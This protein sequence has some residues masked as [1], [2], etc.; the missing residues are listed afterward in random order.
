MNRRSFLV[1]AAAL[2]TVPACSALDSSDSGDAE[3]TEG[4]GTLRLGVLPVIDYTPVYIARDEGLF[5]A[6]GLEVTVES[7][8]GGA[9]LNGI[10]SGDIDVAAATHVLTLNGLNNEAPFRFAW[11][12]YQA[13]AN[14]LVM[15][16]A[17]NSPVQRPQDLP[18]RRVATAVLANVAEL[19]TSIVANQ[20]GVDP[21]SIEWVEIP[22][23]AMGAALETGQVDAIHVVEPFITL[24]G[25]QLGA[26]ILLD[27]AS[28]ATADY[29]LGGYIVTTQFAEENRD[30]VAAFQRAMRRA[31]EMA[32][33]DR[34]LVERTLPTF[35]ELDAET[36]TLLN[37]GVFP[38]SL[39]PTRL[40]R[41]ADAML[42]QDLLDERIDMNDVIIRPAG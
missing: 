20:N 29:P 18:G 15:M 10:V 7:L 28:G 13:S 1:L 42:E 17:P 30:R 4:L 2:S 39:N 37:F 25:T 27:T 38:T 32:N 8:N 22:F 36:A 5:A 21:T 23:D 26:T 24:Y 31:N 16:T 34:S 41:V 6:E 14:T 33:D 12:S 3:G 11:E 19:T 9:A 40:Q 35:T